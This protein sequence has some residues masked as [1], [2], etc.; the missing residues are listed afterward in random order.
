M[1]T[2][3]IS[4]RVPPHVKQFLRENGYNPRHIL[5]SFYAE[6]KKNKLPKLREELKK[7]QE[8]V[9]QLEQSVIQL[10]HEND[11]KI[12]KIAK[13]E[14]EK[15]R[16]GYDLFVDIIKNTFGERAKTRHIKQYLHSKKELSEKE[17]EKILKKVSTDKFS[18][19]DY[20]NVRVKTLKEGD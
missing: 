9:L 4:V 5:E 14:E 13:K 1:E 18:I 6:C 3:N 17:L 19:D 11:I 20:K 2:T 10:E 8:S 16:D 12:E 15:L 7:A